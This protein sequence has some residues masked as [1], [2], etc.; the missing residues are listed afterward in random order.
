MQDGKTKLTGR[1]WQNGN[2]FLAINQ[3]APL[4]KK[5][6]KVPNTNIKA[7]ISAFMRSNTSEPRNPRLL[8][9]LELQHT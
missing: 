6:H 4:M 3:G 5:A 1:T 2:L 7:S 8:E 9:L